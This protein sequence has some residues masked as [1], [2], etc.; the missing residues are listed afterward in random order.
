[1][2]ALKATGGDTAPEKLRQAMLDLK[3]ELPE[4]PL[5]FNKETMVANKDVYIAKIDK[6]GKEYVLNPIY[7]YKDVPALG[8]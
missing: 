2:A 7:T 6:L 3:I 5:S 4:G 1:L 8:Y